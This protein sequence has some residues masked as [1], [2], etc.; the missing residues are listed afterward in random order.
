MDNGHVS[1]VIITGLSG[2]GKTQ[3]MKA[4]E[5]TGYFCIDNLPPSL[6]P[7]IVELQANSS[8]RRNY[9]VAMDIRGQ[10]YFNHLEPA[11]D[12]LEGSGYPHQILFLESQ[13]QVLVRRFSE[14]RRVHPLAHQGSIYDSLA[15]ERKMLA[16]IKR[17]AHVVI[18]TSNLKTSDLRAHLHAAVTGRAVDELM[19]V[20][21]FSFG[22]KYGAPMDADMLFDVRF[23]PN[24]FYVP[25]LKPMTGLDAACAKYVLDRPIT[26]H[27]LSSVKQLLFDLIPHYSSEGKNRLTVG[28]GCTGGQHRSVAITEELSKHMSEGGYSVR[29]RHREFAAGNVTPFV[30]EHTGKGVE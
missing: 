27:F 16:P 10:E 3:S 12:W 29:A 25:E 21:L 18:D 1:F 9:A 5:D 6:L 17:R 28:I 14:V 20:D 2:A 8:E 13:D 19:F 4:L 7:R 11:F 22:F 15:L 30:P 23:V 24:P 26:Q